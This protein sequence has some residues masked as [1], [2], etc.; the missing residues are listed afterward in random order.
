MGSIGIEPLRERQFVMQISQ[1][2]YETCHD[3]GRSQRVREPGMIRPRIGKRSEAELTNAPKP[4]KLG[5][6]QEFFH[7]L[8]FGRFEGNQAMHRVTKYHWRFRV[9]VVVVR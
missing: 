9:N 5:G 3:M 4:L 7:N 1:A 8:L 6:V 2:A